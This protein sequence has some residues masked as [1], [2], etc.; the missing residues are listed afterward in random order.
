MDKDG[1]ADIAYIEP[2]TY[3]FHMGKNSK[4]GDHLRPDQKIGASRDTNQDGKITGDERD[5]N[6]KATAILFHEGGETADILLVARR[7][8][9]MNINVSSI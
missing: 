3:D 2:G 4:Y 5:T 9:Q 1:K 8:L 7:W 6:Y